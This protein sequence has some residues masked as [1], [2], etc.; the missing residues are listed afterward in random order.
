MV[1]TP[2]HY[3]P[4]GL[5]NTS[6]SC[7]GCGLLEDHRGLSERSTMVVSKAK[8]PPRA[9]YQRSGR[10]DRQVFLREFVVQ[11]G[12]AAQAVLP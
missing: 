11:F 7:T 6:Q 4:F 10:Y 12:P 8:T 5:I 9:N 3:D 2:P 1:N